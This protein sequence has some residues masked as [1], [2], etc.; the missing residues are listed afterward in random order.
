MEWVQI[1]DPLGNAWLSTL[2]AALPIL[3]LLGTLAILEW[4]AHWAALA[5]LASALLISVV[6]YGMPARTAAATAVYGA[7]YGLFPI[8][9]IILNAVFLYSLT[10][11]TGQFEIVKRIGRAPVRRSARAGAAHRVLV[12]RVHRR[13]GRLRHAGRDHGGAPH[14]AGLHAA[15]RRRPVAHRQHRA[16]GLWRH[17]H[18]DPDARRRHRHLTRSARARWPDASCRSCRSSCRPGW[19]SR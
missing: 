12:R 3:L 2:A 9:W 6:V 8:G 18:A 13:R 5:G 7:A 16:G 1:Y 4:K 10:V 15:L 19:S 17:R 11:A 14:G